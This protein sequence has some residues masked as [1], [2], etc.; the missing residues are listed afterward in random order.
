MSY[1]TTNLLAEVTAIVTLSDIPVFLGI[2][3]L[4]IIG[5][6]IGRIIFLSV[7]L[8]NDDATSME[9]IDG[10]LLK[11]KYDLLKRENVHNLR[12]LEKIEY[13]FSKYRK[14]KTTETANELKY[15]QNRLK[16]RLE[17]NNNL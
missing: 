14:T 16:E 17:Q 9:E 8:Y 11:L 12:D 13:L 6:S 4:F 1:F 2:I 5:Y 7:E 15:Y 10:K 3:C